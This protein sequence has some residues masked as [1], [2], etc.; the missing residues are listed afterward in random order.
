MVGGC[1][2]CVELEQRESGEREG[3]EAARER[4]QRA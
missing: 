4:D 1:L 3:E 2:W